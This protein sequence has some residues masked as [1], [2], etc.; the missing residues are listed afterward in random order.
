[1][2]TNSIVKDVDLWVFLALFLSC[3]ILHL[4][5]TL[6]V[7]SSA[8]LML[9]GLLLRGVGQYI[10]AVELAVETM[11]EVQESTI[12][13][14][15]LPPL[16]AECAFS[17]DWYTIKREWGQIL[18]L[19]TSAVIVASALTAF[20]LLYV[21]GF[22]D[23]FDWYTAFMLGA[24]LSA[25]DHVSVVAQLK[26]VDA[27]YRLETLIQGETLANE[28]SVIVLF[29]AMMNGAVRSSFTAGDI[30]GQF[31]RLSVGGIALG[32]AFS[33][34][35]SM[36][37]KRLV[38]NTTLEV[39][40]TVITTYMLFFTA[41]A[42]DLKFS[43]AIGT[44]TFGLYMSA[45][46]KTLISP[47]V[48]TAFHEFWEVL[49]TIF[50]SLIFVLGGMLA[51]HFI[52]DFQSL[53]YS[54]IGYLVA[55]FL[56]LHVV[57]AVT[58]LIHWPLLR[59]M[60]Y[61]CSFKEMIVLIVGALKGT[62]SIA[63]ALMV[64]HNEHFSQRV[65]DLILFWS[66]GI[67][68]LS[69]TLDS[70]L[71]SA[72]VHYLGLESMT[73]VEENMLVSV[74]SSILESTRKKMDQMKEDA[75]YAM[76]NWED[77]EKMAGP[78]A[79]FNDMLK[80]TK[81]G[82]KLL[83]QGALGSIPET[84]SK[85][86]QLINITD[87][88]IIL[89]TRRR[90]YTTLK[91]LYWSIFEEHCCFGDSAVLLIQSAN[92]CLDNIREEMR[93]WEIVTSIIYPQRLM[94]FLHIASRLPL[95][96]S[97]F[98][99]LEYSYITQAYDVCRTFINAHKDAE[100]L[101]DD[102]EI[103]IKKDI[104]ERVMKEPHG[105]MELAQLFLSEYITDIYP[106]VYIYVQT[107]Q[108]SSTL[109]YSE[110]TIVD[111]AYYTQGV[112]TELE[113]QALSQSIDQKITRLHLHTSP[114]HPTLS[115]MLHACVLFK[116]LTAGELAQLVAATREEVV[117]QDSVVFESKEGVKAVIVV[118]KGRVREKGI[119]FEREHYP[120]DVVGLQYALPNSIRTNTSAVAVIQ[121]NLAYIPISAIQDLRTSDIFEKTLWIEGLK[122]AV[123]VS[124]QAFGPLGL[125]E[126]VTLATVLSNCT[127]IAPAAGTQVNLACSSILVEGKLSNG[128]KAFAFI[129]G[130]E[131]ANAE[132]VINCTLMQFSAKFSAHVRTFSLDLVQAV[133]SF[134]HPEAS[135]A[136]RIRL[137]SLL[138]HVARP[139]PS[140]QSSISSKEEPKESEEEL[141]ARAPLPQLKN[142]PKR[143]KIRQIVKD[144]Q[145][146]NKLDVT[147]A[148]SRQEEEKDDDFGF[149][150]KK[151]T[152]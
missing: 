135:T 23:V 34:L 26:E 21:L 92:R 112:I 114:T 14:I 49:A 71:M 18:L 146:G 2:T 100:K 94:R 25:T 57:R 1:M 139:Q 119:G 53:E 147:R 118:L 102:L 44:V 85:F 124:K 148:D 89:E 107:K 38:N 84:L 145:G 11:D 29:T 37:L 9:A 47:S 78:E 8:L 86:S 46:G 42:T 16:I 95:L 126:P 70:L 149:Y 99:R 151:G 32:I 72:T 132:A 31:F 66:V 77:V 20:V 105:Q 76:V 104:F 45:Y 43:G 127:L 56:L 24:I 58:I 140:P 75:S 122:R 133:N 90:Y 131:G 48:E 22:R 50:Q 5:Q 3:L 15:F 59:K 97:Y 121:T 19:A 98:R 68:A 52:S 129:E 60:G 125:L 96:G 87:E 67:S 101:L 115:D 33:V 91:G 81:T 143:H 80:A 55:L 62:I 116:Q 36:W 35:L 10:G 17:T 63:L 4:R 150:P 117:K 128:F 39:L 7:P 111:E 13:L 106:E 74:S 12:L 138:Q 54:D 108:A 137:L 79:L 28:G 109:L 134:E 110:K 83:Q 136:P 142:G 123:Q 6:R 141:T 103:D 73:N 93:D 40:L 82:L 51:A 69:V 64:Y 152:K 88:D 30:V 120:G 144:L 61:G 27:D 113:F 41:E 130:R 65:R